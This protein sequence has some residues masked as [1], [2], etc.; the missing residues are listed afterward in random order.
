MSFECGGPG[1]PLEAPGDVLGRFCGVKKILSGVKKFFFH[2]AK[3]V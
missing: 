1:V 2:V 3:I